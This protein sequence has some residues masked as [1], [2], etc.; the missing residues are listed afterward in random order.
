MKH[1]LKC[2]PCNSYTLKEACAVCH[3]PTVLAIPPRYSPDDKYGDYRRK[4]KA[5]TLLQ[6]GLL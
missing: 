4:V 5:V 6:D 3:A 2:L 1:L